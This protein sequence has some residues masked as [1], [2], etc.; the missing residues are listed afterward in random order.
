MQMPN[1][2]HNSMKI[3]GAANEIARFKQTCLRAADP[4]DGEFGLFA[5][6]SVPLVVDFNAI[7]PMPLDSIFRDDPMPLDL[8]RPYEEWKVACE[9]W[10]VRDAERLV[11]FKAITGFDNLSDWCWKHWGTPKQYAFWLEISQDEAKC[12]DCSFDTAWGPPVPVWEKIGE[13]FPTLTFELGGCE[14][15]NDDAFRGTIKRGK[16]RLRDVPLMWETTDPETGKQVRGTR[17]E[18]GA[19]ADK[20]GA[21]T[22][23]TG[24]TH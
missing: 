20:G 11:Q 16:L 9:E 7:I 1:W 14:P 13:L 23:S 17:E 4:D 12:F 5:Q 2:V 8:T 21:V 19:L 15:L 22:Y 24:N 6:G 3:T 10:K 18:I